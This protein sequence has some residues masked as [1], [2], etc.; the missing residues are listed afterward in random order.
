MKCRRL[1]PAE[2]S[3][4]KDMYQTMSD[5]EIASRIGRPSGTIAAY[6]DRAGLKREED[7]RKNRKRKKEIAMMPNTAISSFLSAKW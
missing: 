7:L 5:V 1:N 6:R 3:A 4:I 2:M